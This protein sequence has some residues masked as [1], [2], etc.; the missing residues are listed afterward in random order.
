MTLTDR[1]AGTD[2][3]DLAEHRWADRRVLSWTV[4]L[5][6]VGVPL[7]AAG[8]VAS[9]HLSVFDR[10]SGFTAQVLF[11]VG[12]VI[13]PVG[14]ALFLQHWTA[15]LLPL[16]DL[17][18]L[19]LAFPGPPPNRLVAS[20]READAHRLE[21]RLIG[22]DATQDPSTA[23]NLIA[24]VGLLRHHDHLTRGH[25]E[26]VAAYAELIGAEMGLAR[27]DLDRLKWGALIHDV[28]KL[29]VPPHVLNA[30]ESLSDADRQL[31]RNHPVAATAY[32]GVV[33]S[34][35]GAWA[36]AALEHHERWDGGGYPS[37]LRGEEI[38]LAGR[39][40]AVAD[41]YDVMTSTTSYRDALG[42]DQA[43]VEIARSAGSQFDPAAV[44][45]LLQLS[46]T[47]LRLLLGPRGWLTERVRVMSDRP[48]VRA[49]GVAVAATVI[50]VSSAALVQPEPP[51][52]V[53]TAA[54]RVVDTATTTTSVTPT[55]V[56]TERGETTTTTTAPSTTTTTTTL[57]PP[58][59]PTSAPITTTTL[60]PLFV[61]PVEPV[62]ISEPVGRGFV[63]V[64]PSSITGHLGD[65]NLTSDEHAF[66]WFEPPAT[67]E[68]PVAV[69]SFIDGVAFAGD[70][71]GRTTIPP[72]TSVCSLFVHTD[73]NQS[74]DPIEIEIDVGVVP[75]CFAMRGE[76]LDATAS[77]G[78]DGLDHRS[79][80]L[81][82]DDTGLV[83]GTTM[84]FT[85]GHTVAGR[86]QVRVFLPC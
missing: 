19:S 32:L 15:R 45:A 61:A 79:D 1:A 41:A 59:P 73:P 60:A 58:Q 83:T 3:A 84:R 21:E 38:G 42:V 17:L 7:L 30:P 23:Q 11:W 43:R 71:E 5:V 67:T 14:A 24:L 76:E 48:T 26:R 9:L 12:L 8:V 34:W 74:V 82:I 44:R 36:L 85:M 55:E 50:A 57:A 49:A 2:T 31:V 66:I 13:G 29:S 78:V 75:L 86:D 40:V 81:G 35:L 54:E 18:R 52:L 56:L 63:V 62:I 64:D 69:R 27:D 47:R 6:A 33:S 37:G 72:G 20:L 46:P 51:D 22:A 68:G 4:R 16:A 80:G 65:G 28:G 53:E 25:S 39:I 70:L 77:H 10:P